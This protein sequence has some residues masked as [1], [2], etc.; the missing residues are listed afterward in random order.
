MFTQSSYPDND[1][2]VIQMNVNDKVIASEIPDENDDIPSLADIFGED[3]FVDV[4]ADYSA[5]I[6]EK[7]WVI[8]GICTEGECVIISGDSKS[9]KSYLMTNLAI[10]AA[11]GGMWLDRF[12]CKPCRVLYFNGEN[13]INDARERFQMCCR[14][15]KMDPNDSKKIHM[16]CT[17]GIIKTIQDLKDSLKKD[18]NKKHYG[19]CILDPLYCF[20]RGSEIDEEDAKE[21]VEA[22]KEV[23]RETG[24][25]IFCVHHH[26]KN[27]VMTYK[28]ASNRASGSG[29]LQRGFS[30]LLDVTEINKKGLKLTTAQRAYE[31]TG[32]PRQA[33][34]FKM[35]LIFDFPVWKSDRDCIIPDNAIN[36][37]RTAQARQSNG[38]IQKSEKLR[39]VLP[40]AMEEA[41]YE[42]AAEDKVGKYVTVGNMKEWLL[43][44]RAI[45]VS[46]RTVERN[47]DDGY[48]PGYKR[49]NQSRSKIRKEEFMNPPE[50]LT[51]EQLPKSS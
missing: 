35:N 15:M 17:D 29:M 23:C 40:D 25:V 30:A 6:P 37:E 48:A 16:F 1:V 4:I 19:L 49:D 41:F 36:K 27:G 47:I 10:E 5:K 39:V 13:S 8:E 14:S 26:S 32:Q 20:Y 7:K 43:S 18:I 31:F 24:A 21:F 12:K 38:N 50:L 46:E 2:K 51:P 42:I 11:R 9:G 34:N 44:T 33:E 3:T 22:I 45:D 28:N